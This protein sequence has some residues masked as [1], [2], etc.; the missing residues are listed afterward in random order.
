VGFLKNGKRLNQF[1]T[2]NRFRFYDLLFLDVLLKYNA[3]GSKLFERMFAKNHPLTIFR[4]LDEKTTF[5]EEL[6]ILS[7]FSLI[8]IRWFLNALIK[9]LF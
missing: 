7:S 5:L 4:F 9:R 6:K 8:Q 3:Q 2:K 1:Q